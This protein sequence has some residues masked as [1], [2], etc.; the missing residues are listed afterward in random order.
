MVSRSRVHGKMG[1]IFPV[2]F[3]TDFVGITVLISIFGVKLKYEKLILAFW[4]Q[5]KKTLY[6]VDWIGFVVGMGAHTRLLE[7]LIIESSSPKRLNVNL[8]IYSDVS[9]YEKRLINYY[10]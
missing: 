8:Q 7:S 3:L 1:N 9:F 2:V 5:D 4:A 6:W 10:V